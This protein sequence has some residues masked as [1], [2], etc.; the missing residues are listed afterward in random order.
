MRLTAL[1]IASSV[2][3]SC[4]GMS[5]NNT[6]STS[7]QFAVIFDKTF[8]TAKDSDGSIIRDRR[9]RIK[10]DA[11]TGVWFYSQMNTGEDF[12]L[13]RQRVYNFVERD[14]GQGLVQKAYGLND[15]E[16]YADVWERPEL[17]A[18]LTQD[19]FKPT[20]NAGCDP[21]WTQGSNGDWSG[22]VDPQTCVID[23][24]RRNM[25]IRIESES[26]LSADLYQTTERGYD[27][28]MNFLWGSKPGEMNTRFV[29]QP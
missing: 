3:S 5:D 14:D 29:T 7:E 24:K 6:P 26:F 20:F 4:A 27:I 12:K 22:Y 17:L 9:M 13:Y 18:Q 11:L 8:E 16:R 1:L 15:P 25:Q 23:S 21:Q 19:D 10:S 2:L 28:D